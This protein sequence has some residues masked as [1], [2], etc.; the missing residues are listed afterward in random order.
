RVQAI[1]LPALDT[2]ET[3]DQIG[4]APELQS[5]IYAFTQGHP[6]ANEMVYDV[7]QQHLLGALHPRQVLAEQRTRIAER[8]ISAIYSRVLG[9]VS[10]EL[11]QIFGVIALFR[12]FDIHTLRTVLPTFEP[13]FVHRSDSALL[14]SLKQLLDTRLVTWSDERRAYQIDPTIRQIFSYALRWS[15]TERYLD[16]RDAAITYYRQLIQD[17]P[18][19][20]NVYIVEY[21]YQA[22]YKGDREIYNQDAFKEAIQHYYFSPDQRYR[23]DQALGQ[24]RERF[25]DDP[26]LAGLLAERKLAPRHFLAVLDVFL[27]Q[28]L[29]ANV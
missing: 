11:A 23:A 1:H 14:L 21:Y 24:L 17:V 10:S 28:P 3:L 18:G 29:A 20:R 25:L 4:C 19:N 16:I 15:H 6:L 27:E 2:Q 9:G 13:A 26:E 22:L 5:Q 8:I 12:E 7:L